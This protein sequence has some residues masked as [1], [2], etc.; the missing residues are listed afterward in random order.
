MGYVAIEVLANEVRGVAP[1]PSEQSAITNVG[2]T[3]Y[4]SFRS[5]PATGSEVRLA[6]CPP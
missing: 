6:L 2:I 4:G 5:T 3:A 1:G